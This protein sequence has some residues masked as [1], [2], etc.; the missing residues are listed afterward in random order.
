MRAL[1]GLA[2]RL[3]GRLVPQA[4]AAAAPCDIEVERCEQGFRYHC[5]YDRCANYLYDCTFI[6]YC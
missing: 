5:W 2:D 4:E 3:L 1:N 6:G